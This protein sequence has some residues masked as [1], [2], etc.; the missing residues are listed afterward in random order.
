MYWF[1]SVRG[2]VEWTVSWAC[3]TLRFCL[4]FVFFLCVLVSTPFYSTSGLQCAR[5]WVEGGRDGEHVLLSITIT[6][7][8]QRARGLGSGAVQ[9][10]AGAGGIK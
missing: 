5:V 9:T 1:V 2:L 6:I 8:Y 3:V 10:E 7:N 4:V